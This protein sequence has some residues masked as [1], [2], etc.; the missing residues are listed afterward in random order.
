VPQSLANILLHI[1]FSTKDRAPLIPAEAAS[2]LYEY[3]AAISRAYA[4]PAHEVGGTE[5]HVHICCSLARTQT[6]ANLVEEIKKGSSKWMK[7]RTRPVMGFA[8]QNG[9]GAFSIGESQLSAVKD[10]IRHQPEHH[11]AVSFEDELRE[12]LRRHGITYDER[13]LWTRISLCR[14]FRARLYGGRAHPGRCPGLSSLAPSGLID[15]I[16]DR[17]EARR[18]REPRR[19][20]KREASP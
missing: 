8:W 15:R 10:Y 4:C 11:A 7:A 13:Y 2:G 17:R 1:V 12:L 9:Y 14:P 6:C 3:P 18:E 16:G 20:A 19:E 5:D